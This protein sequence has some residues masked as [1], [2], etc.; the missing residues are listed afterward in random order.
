MNPQESLHDLHMIDL[1]AQMVKS[2]PSNIETM[3]SCFLSD[4][5][6]FHFP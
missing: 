1:A 3:P 5:T 4:C 6:R 2:S